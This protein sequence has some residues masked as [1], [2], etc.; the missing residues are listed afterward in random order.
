[1]IRKSTPSD[2][3]AISELLLKAFSP[4]SYEAQLR[5]LVVSEDDFHEW[6][7]E[8]KGTIIAHILYSPALRSSTKIGYHLAPVCVHPD[9]Q[10]QGIGTQLIRE[11]LQ[12]AELRDESIFVLGDP[13]L[14]E[15]FG[16]LKT[17]NARCPYD[18]SNQHFRALR[19]NTEDPKFA[20]EYPPAFTQAGE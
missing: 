10:K 7:L 15:R 6:V 1:M 14:Y 20:I 5:V 11:T 13:A 17:W 4:S 12:S 3:A 18:S 2:S 8:V 16:F 19:W 9:H